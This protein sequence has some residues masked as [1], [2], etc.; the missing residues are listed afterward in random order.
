MLNYEKLIDKPR[1]FLAATG[2]T[3]VE[4]ERLLPVFQAAYANTYPS[5]RTYEGK[6]RQ[7]RA[8]AGAKGTL[9]GFADKLLFILVYQK[10]NPLQVMHGLQF[11]LSQS[12][13]NY[14]IHRLLSVLRHAL[15]E[16]GQAPERD[17]QRVATSAL[18]LAGAPNLAVDGTER[19]RQRPR[20]AAQQK[21][22]YSG[23]KKTH[24][25][26]NILL[27]NE[28]TG[29]VVYLGPTLPGKTHDKKAADEAVIAYRT[30][31][32]LDKDTG[33]QGYEPGGVLTTQPKKS[34]Q[35]K[36]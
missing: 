5:E 18:A 35:A 16:A 25:D 36:S 30:N 9:P 10:T 28:H 29:K 21:D 15:R 2:L 12:Q 33:F 17:A 27:V 1:E 24:T 8:G 20:D 19:R 22:H 26:K 3:L 11:E 4:F 32:T 34:P 31:T 14:W 13:A 23:K 6:A 7:R